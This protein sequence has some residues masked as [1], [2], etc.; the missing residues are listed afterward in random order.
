MPDKWLAITYSLENET[1]RKAGNLIKPIL[2]VG[3]NPDPNSK[4]F[5]MGGEGTL[6]IDEG[7]RWMVD[8]DEAEKEGM[9]IRMD[10]SE[11]ESQKGIDRLIVV[12]LKYSADENTSSALLEEMIENHHYTDGIAFVPQGTPTNNTDEKKSGFNSKENYET[13]FTVEVS[14]PLYIPVDDPLKSKDGELVA[15]AFGLPPEFFNHVENSNLTEQQDAMALY[16]GLFSRGV[17]GSS[18]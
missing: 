5:D 13:I 6:E 15:N 16:N 1:H 10:I 9:A 8:F 14:D 18:F 17:D 11:A 12:G 2:N 7:I 4:K 3:F